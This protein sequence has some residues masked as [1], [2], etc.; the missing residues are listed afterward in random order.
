MFL[1]QLLLS[2]FVLAFSGNPGLDL[3]VIAGCSN[4]EEETPQISLPISSDVII[5]YC[6][7][8]MNPLYMTQTICFSYCS[9]G[10]VMSSLPPN[11][12]YETCLMHLFPM[13]KN[14]IF[15]PIKGQWSPQE[16][17][18][19]A[20]DFDKSNAQGI[21]AFLKY[22]GLKLGLYIYNIHIL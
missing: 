15:R 12:K 13:Y 2:D 18:A 16:Q 5:L 14:I 9:N 11:K 1:H 7:G 22:P 4:K 3:Q 6:K 20:T 10:D 8:S 19:S 21:S 17:E